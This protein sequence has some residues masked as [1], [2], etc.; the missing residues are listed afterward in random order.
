M[1]YLIIVKKRL[2]KKILIILGVCSAG[3]M[4]SCA[5]YGTLVSTIYMNLK[6]T[7]RS[8]DSS[9]VISGIQV[10]LKNRLPESKTLTD[11]NGLFSVNS[12]IDELENTLN[13]H[14]SDVDG[15]LNGSYLSK[16]T[17]ITLSPNEKLAQIKENID[18]RLVKNE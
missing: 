6:G 3:L 2:L 14:I 12:E 1:K 15:A 11:N 18:I 13:L 9:Q 10:E 17:I 8:K 4:A 7:I 5:K 16:D